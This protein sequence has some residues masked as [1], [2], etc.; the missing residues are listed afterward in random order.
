M[1][2]KVPG[3]FA[4]GRSSSQGVAATPKPPDGGGKKRQ[5][6]KQVIPRSWR[7]LNTDAG[8]ESDPYQETDGNF[9][10]QCD[11]ANFKI[12]RSRCL[13][14]SDRTAGKA[15]TGCEPV[16]RVNWLEPG[17][18]RDDDGLVQ[19]DPRK[20]A[21]KVSGFKV[22]FQNPHNFPVSVRCTCARTTRDVPDNVNLRVSEVNRELPSKA[23]FTA[24]I[25]K[26]SAEGYLAYTME[27]DKR[28]YS[29]CD[30]YITV[31]DHPF[32]KTLK[33]K[34]IE[35]GDG[36]EGGTLLQH[37][38]NEEVWDQRAEILDLE[39]KANYTVYNGDTDIKIAPRVAEFYFKFNN[40]LSTLNAITTPVFLHGGKVQEQR[41][42]WSE[43][44]YDVTLEGFLGIGVAFYEGSEGES[45]PYLAK[46][47]KAEK[48]RRENRPKR[49][50]R[51]P[52]S[53][54]DANA[55][56]ALRIKKLEGNYLIF[57]PGGAAYHDDT[58]GYDLGLPSMA[59]KFSP[60][61]QAFVQWNFATSTV[62]GIPDDFYYPYYYQEWIASM[63]PRGS[64]MVHATPTPSSF[65]VKVGNFNVNPELA[66]LP[67]EG[68]NGW[69]DMP[70]VDWTVVIQATIYVLQTA[71]KLF[72]VLNENFSN[73]G[74]SDMAPQRRKQLFANNGEFRL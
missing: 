16:V 47:P 59:F 68:P 11:Q 21:V 4:K 15:P 25:K 23:R 71:L 74:G 12:D 46:F 6:K 14:I 26:E 67:K 43:E 2:P 8:I 5:Q 64:L 56:P 62:V 32:L 69:N 30:F 24:N 13:T 36:E 41:L 70:H 60:K 48:K 58:S 1:P 34:I 38:V 28:Y 72:Q 65:A 49:E 33:P 61:H 51:G 52:P 44:P 19:M 3:N 31:P 18:Y 54:R 55:Y 35:I 50:N 53:V 63:P 20:V 39:V 73:G 7:T 45:V 57:F 10:R 22:T 40:D 9:Q 66:L 27:G 42:A 29:V 37:V 17:V